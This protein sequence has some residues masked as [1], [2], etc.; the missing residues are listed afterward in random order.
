[1]GAVALP[2]GHGP[3]PGSPLDLRFVA[4]RGA[5]GVVAGRRQNLIVGGVLDVKKAGRA[6]SRTG[7]LFSGVENLISSLH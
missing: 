4:K 3:G 5:A 7:E 6:L 2:A 1:M